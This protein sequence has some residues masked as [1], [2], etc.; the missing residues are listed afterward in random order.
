MRFTLATYVERSADNEMC[1]YGL[2]V[3]NYNAMTY[4]LNYELLG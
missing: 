4:I 2:G 3:N 1:I